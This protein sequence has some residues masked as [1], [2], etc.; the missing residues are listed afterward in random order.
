MVRSGREHPVGV[1]DLAQARADQGQGRVVGDVEEVVG[2]QVLVA[3]DLAGEDAGGLDGRLQGR[4]LGLLGDGEGALHVGEAAP[5]L[6]A[7]QVAGDEADVGVGRVDRVGPD[8]RKGD[9]AARRAHLLISL[10]WRG[11]RCSYYI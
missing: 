7:D 9:G 5:Y 2:A 10:V 4:V 6:R 1:V 11:F 8:L 3:L